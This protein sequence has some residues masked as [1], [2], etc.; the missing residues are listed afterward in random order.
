MGYSKTLDLGD[1]FSFGGS[2]IASI[3]IDTVASDVDCGSVTIPTLNSPIKHVYVDLW[4][5]LVRNTNVL[6]NWIHPACNLLATRAGTSSTCLTLDDA[7][8]W[9][10]VGDS[11]RVGG[12]FHGQ[13][14]VA[15]RFIS[16]GTTT[17]KL[18]N[19]ACQRTQMVLSDMQ[20]IVKVVL[21]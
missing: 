8:I 6:T 12:V 13:N 11:V 1:N 5:G 2:F 14:D 21:G 20:C 17:F 16:G 19:I 3:G 4:I 10:P 15:S 9:C 18:D 7:S